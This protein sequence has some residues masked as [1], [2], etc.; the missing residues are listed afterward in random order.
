MDQLAAMRVF[1]CLAEARGFSAAAER[2][3]VTHSSVSRQLKQ[4]E[5]ELG[6]QLVQRNPRRFALT[7]A[8]E[9]YYADCVDIL[10]RVA[11]A[12][13]ALSGE[14]QRIAGRLRVSAALTIGTQELGDWLPP[15][16]KRYPDI[17]LELSCSDDFVDLVGAGFD[18]ALRVSK[19]L[20]DSGLVARTLAVSDLVLVAAPDYVAQHGV[21][22]SAD[23]LARHRL[24]AYLGGRAASHWSVLGK[25]R[26]PTRVA[27][28][29]ALR[30]DTTTALH[31]AALAGAGIAAF[32]HITVRSDLMRGRLI[33]I[34]PGH[35]LGR[36]GYYALH[37]Q[38]RHVPPKVRAFVQ[39]MQQ[40]YAGM[41]A[42]R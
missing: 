30:A 37:A 6:V 38:A 32:T 3:D 9:R 12:A 18:V 17:Q 39:H 22:Q 11:A 40:H 25:D 20:A 10:D 21:P 5:T 16:Q 24:L 4:L 7:E 42:E 1:R 33:A 41:A 27:L 23:E 2:L 31:A 15:F 13:Q 14:Q 34:L 8:G 29:G 26:A 19:P 36:R 28:R 35:T